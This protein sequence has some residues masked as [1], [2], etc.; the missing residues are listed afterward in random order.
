[1][2]NEKINLNYENLSEALIRIEFIGIKTLAIEKNNV[3]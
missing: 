2:P 3:K 1:M